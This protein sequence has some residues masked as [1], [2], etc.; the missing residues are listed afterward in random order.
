[1]TSIHQ[2]ASTGYQKNAD[3]YQSGRPDY[4]AASLDW[5][6][7][8]LA[9]GKNSKVVDLGAGTGKFTKRIC[10]VSD[11]VIAVEPVAA[12]RETLQ[13]NLPQVETPEGNALDIPLPDQSV[14]ALI[15]A[16]SFHWFASDLAVNEM[17]RVLRPGGKLGLIWNVRDENVDWVAA[18]TKLITPYEGDAPRYY[19]G[20]WQKPLPSPHFSPLEKQSFMQSHD[21]PAEEVIV[22]RFLS[23]SFIA[24]QPEE[25]QAEIAEQLR[26][27]TATHDALKGKEQVSF[28][29][30]TEAF[31]ATRL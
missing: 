3:K 7:D 5:M 26:Q 19:K 4:A 28:P 27:L 21:G 18:I 22:N 8:A 20:D 6:R 13:A 16:Q 2:S 10:E 9:V 25:V 14:D 23:V 12:M 15:C 1:M 31:S 17:A 11:H 30:V 29:Y 24:A